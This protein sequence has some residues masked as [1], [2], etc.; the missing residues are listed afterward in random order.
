MKKL[1]LKNGMTLNVTVSK[2][3]EGRYIS[4]Y[5]T[6]QADIFYSV[7]SGNSAMDQTVIFGE[8]KEALDHYVVM[9]MNEII[10]NFDQYFN[11]LNQ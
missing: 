4:V 2:E 11:N 8:A 7:F 3:T 6:P 1:F 10:E 5:E 9:Q